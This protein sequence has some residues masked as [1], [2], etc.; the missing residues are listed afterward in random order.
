M[1]IVAY[2]QLYTEPVALEKVADTRI[3]IEDSIAVIHDTAALNQSMV[4]FLD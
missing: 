1:T 2:Y 3:V 4:N